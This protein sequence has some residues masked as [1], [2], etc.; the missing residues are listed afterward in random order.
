MLFGSVSLLMF[1]VSCAP[2]LRD[3]GARSGQA[4]D[5]QLWSLP[6][7]GTL[8]TPS[9]GRISKIWAFSSH[10]RCKA[11]FRFGTHVTRGP[12]AIAWRW[13]RRAKRMGAGLWA[14]CR[15]WTVASR[16]QLL[17]PPL[18]HM[19]W[20]R[21]PPHRRGEHSCAECQGQRSDR[22]T[23][24]RE[25]E[26]Y[27]RLPRCSVAPPTPPA[28]ARIWESRSRSCT[29]PSTSR[30]WWRHEQPHPCICTGS[31]MP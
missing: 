6:H 16:A 5:A 18:R 30:S 15:G 22:S 26:K 4:G 11:R 19:L 13:R 20:D 1:V 27:L 21:A 23:I 9:Q 7:V 24:D 3:H 31:L 14:L 12:L 17:A 29:R 25:T 8:C 28:R 10:L 2:L